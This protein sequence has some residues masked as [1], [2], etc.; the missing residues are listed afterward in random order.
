MSVESGTRQRRLGP[1]GVAARGRNSIPDRRTGAKDGRS[2]GVCGRNAR[3]GAG[4]RAPWSILAVVVFLL[5][6]VHSFIHSLYPTRFQP[7]FP[8]LCPAGRLGGQPTR[9]GNFV[10]RRP[11]SLLKTRAI[12]P[13]RPAVSPQPLSKHACPAHLDNGSTN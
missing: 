4:R 8:Q 10:P 2:A 6:I 7:R 1:T 11:T 9:R 13:Q 5:S 12:C 3:E